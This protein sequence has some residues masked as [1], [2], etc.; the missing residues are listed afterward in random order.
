MLNIRKNDSKQSKKGIHN[1]SL[2]L[3]SDLKPIVLCTVMKI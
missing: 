1:H 3:L 2:L